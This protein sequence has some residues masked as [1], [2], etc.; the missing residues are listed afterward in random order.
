MLVAAMNPCPCGHLGDS[1]KLCCCSPLAVARY[2]AR[3]SGPL[4]DRIDIHVEV[5]AVRYRELAAAPDGESST[6]V[7]ARVDQARARQLARFR[8]ALDLHC[9]AQMSTRQIRK[10]CAVG[11]E[12]ERLLAQVVDRLGMSAR[13]HDRILRVARTIADLEGSEAIDPA[14]LAEAIQYRTLDR[15]LE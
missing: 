7:R 13:A 5:P 10:L 11:P 3:V 2:R 15:R 12:G 8:K 4:L 9:N 1:Q 14:H 6:S